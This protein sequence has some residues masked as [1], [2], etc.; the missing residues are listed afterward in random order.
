MNLHGLV[1]EVAGNADAFIAS[2]DSLHDA[3]EAVSDYV[4]E[5]YPE[6]SRKDVKNVVNGVMR[7]LEEEAQFQGRAAGPK[8]H[9]ARDVDDD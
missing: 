9:R 5:N 8:R 3:R 4:E 2:A 6:L 1:D 7:L